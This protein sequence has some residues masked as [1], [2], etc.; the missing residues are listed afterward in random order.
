MKQNGGDACGISIKNQVLYI[1]LNNAKTRSGFSGAGFCVLY[2]RFGLGV[3]RV[4]VVPA[5]C[6]F[7]AFL[8]IGYAIGANLMAVFTILPIPMFITPDVDRVCF[9]VPGFS[10]C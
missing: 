5:F 9:I 3:L 1:F 7:I 2:Q 8:M 4:E 10:A 6:L